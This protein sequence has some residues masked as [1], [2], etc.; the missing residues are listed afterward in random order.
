MKCSL[1]SSNFLEEISSLSQSIVSSI[2]LGSY[3]FSFLLTLWGG[4]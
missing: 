1:D 3:N 4:A 2:S